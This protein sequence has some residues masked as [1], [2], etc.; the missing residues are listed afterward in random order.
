MFLMRFY[1][2][3][4]KQQDD[5]DDEL[6]SEIHYC[7]LDQNA[8]IYWGFK[9]ST[10]CNYN[11]SETVTMEKVQSGYCEGFSIFGHQVGTKTVCTRGPCPGQLEPALDR[12]PKKRA[13]LQKMI[14]D[15]FEDQARSPTTLG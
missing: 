8:S 12:L 15:S 5:D 3:T 13:E 2:L 4:E 1:L 9:G 7:D 14:M 6:G 10:G 11:K